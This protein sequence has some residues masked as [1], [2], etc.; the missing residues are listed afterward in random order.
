MRAQRVPT[1]LASSRA[2][3][4][5]EVARHRAHIFDVRIVASSDRNGADRTLINVRSNM[6]GARG[7]APIPGRA[8]SL[9]V[10]CRE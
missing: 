6:I 2:F 3:P 7:L 4:G 5:A 9:L 8:S 10:L 1:P